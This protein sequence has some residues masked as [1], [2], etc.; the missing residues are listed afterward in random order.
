[1]TTPLPTFTKQPN[2]KYRCDICE[3]EMIRRQAD[4]HK[5]GDGCILVLL[6]KRKYY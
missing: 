1:M 2:G 4:P 3:A 6:E 5:L